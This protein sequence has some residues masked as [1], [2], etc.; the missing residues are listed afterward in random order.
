MLGRTNEARA[1]IEPAVDTMSELLRLDPRNA[2]IQMVFVYA[3]T[4]YEEVIA[5]QA[6]KRPGSVDP[7]LRRALS[8]LDQADEVI[9]PLLPQLVGVDA[10]FAGRID[11]GRQ[12]CTE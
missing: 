9:K 4:T 10:E 3:A 8:L 12:E 6:R 1:L 11:P 2:T 7:Q 5:A